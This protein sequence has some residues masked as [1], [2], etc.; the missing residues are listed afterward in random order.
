M[1]NI[2]LVLSGGGARGAFQA[3]V[4]K[5]LKN[6]DKINI[7]KVSGT[8]VGALNGSMVSTNN[9]EYLKKIWLKTIPFWS[10]LIGHKIIDILL[11][12]Y[13]FLENIRI[14]FYFNFYSL[15]T[16][17]HVITSNEKFK[18]NNE[19]R[20]AIKASATI[21]FILRSKSIDKIV[22][23][24]EVYT[25]CVD[26][27]VVD[28]ALRIEDNSLKTL[29]IDCKNTSYWPYDQNRNSRINDLIHMMSRM[30]KK[31]NKDYDYVIKPSI[32]DEENKK[33]GS[34]YKF[35][36]KEIKKSYDLGFKKG[37]EF[38]EMI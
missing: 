13:V 37:L 24:D 14:P 23:N 3:G 32:E 27:G 1:I 5:A 33:I 9:I 15:S 4:L 28:R 34:T 38:L 30:T 31:Q 25:K 20:K 21:P 12:R 17:K 26:G 2:N 18:N 29:L 35:S 6:S 8:S 10:K 22:I 16:N 7:K 19:F 36:K 11:N